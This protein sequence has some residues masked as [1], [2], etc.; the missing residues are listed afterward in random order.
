MARLAGFEPATTWFEATYYIDNFLNVNSY[1]LDITAPHSS[2]I[3]Q[4]NIFINQ[5]FI[6]HHGAVNITVVVL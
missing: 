1:L 4:H 6:P 3:T 2:D 5:Y